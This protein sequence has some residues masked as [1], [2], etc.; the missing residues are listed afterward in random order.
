MAAGLGKFL[1][2]A[3]ASQKLTVAS[4]VQTADVGAGV[5]LRTITTLSVSGT[6]SPSVT[7]S[8]ASTSYVRNN[9]LK[10]FSGS[11][12][13]WIS[14]NGLYWVLTANQDGSE[15]GAWWTSD[16]LISANW[17]PHGTATGVATT[18]ATVV[19]NPAA[20]PL[21]QAS[22][23][24]SLVAAFQ[25]G[26]PSDTAAATK[27]A[28]ETSESADGLPAIRNNTTIALSPPI[29]VSGDTAADGYFTPQ[30]SYN[31]AIYYLS[32]QSYYIWKSSNTPTKYRISESIGEAT[33]YWEK[34]GGPT[35]TYNPRGSVAGNPVAARYD[36]TT[37]PAESAVAVAASTPAAGFFTNSLAGIG[38]TEEQAEQ[39][40][41]LAATLCG[42]AGKVVLDLSAKTF[43]VYDADNAQILYRQSFE[44]TSTTQTFLA[45][46]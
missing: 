44:T 5:S 18:A 35:G 22:P 38:L 24:T 45:Q 27:T 23:S 31:G 8:Y 41:L 7:G 43:T 14:F 12:Y 13:Y 21:E 26:L 15:T 6:L 4:E 3:A 40:S 20:G 10:W 25:D 46:T 37:I 32:L 36:P 19:L 2:V 33:D 42:T 17:Q 30:G 9:A 11:T 28:L 39:L 16:A 1:N 34:T 29:V